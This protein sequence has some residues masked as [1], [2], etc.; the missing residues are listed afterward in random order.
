MPMNGRMRHICQRLSGYRR[1]AGL[2]LAQVAQAVGVLDP[3][4]L[5]EMEE[6]YREPSLE[7]F[8][9]LAAL[10][11][12]SVDTLAGWEDPRRPTAEATP[13][14]TARR[15]QMVQYVEQ[16]AARM[17]ALLP[18]SPVPEASEPPMPTLKITPELFA[19]I[20]AYAQAHGRR[21]GDI[22]LQAVTWRIGLN[23]EQE[24]RY[25][26]EPEG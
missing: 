7:L 11:G 19:A 10:Y 8:C 21:V 2:S 15:A 17:R 9:D 14:I 5:R 6:G 26:P 16:T 23:R 24:E 1:V 25:F 3:V 13:G 20:T 12:V 18:P 4:V 22:L